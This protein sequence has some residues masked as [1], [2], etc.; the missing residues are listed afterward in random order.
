MG[1][2]PSNEELLRAAC[3]QQEYF[4]GGSG[5]TFSGGIPS[6]TPVRAQ[7]L[8]LLAVYL[9]GTGAIVSGQQ[10]TSPPAIR[11]VRPVTFPAY[12]AYRRIE[13]Y[14]PTPDEYARVVGDRAFVMERV[15]YR[16]DGLDVYAYLYRPAVPP[17]N[18]TLPVAVYNRGSYIRDDFSPEVLMLANRLARQGFLVVAPMLR[19]S[20]GAQGRDEMGGAD[21]H[22]VLNIVPVIRELPYADPTRL[23]LYGESR[24]GIMSLLAARDGFPA[25]AIAVWGAITDFRLYLNEDSATRRLAPTIWPD[26]PANEAAILESR[27]AMRWPE[28][29]NVPV[30]LMNGGADTQVSPLYAIQFAA[31]LAKL[32]KPYELKIFHGENHIATRRAQE[33]DDDAVRWFRRFDAPPSKP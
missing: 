2:E 31:A 5:G 33:R 11:D 22:D 20:G 29:I 23:F 26:F 12:G 4:S 25:R 21:L 28:K 27:S 19:G 17:G 24:G 30:L 9:G 3:A 7:F 13:L 16:S 1:R 8:V 6:A 32:G 10:A 18:Q 14:A 15:T